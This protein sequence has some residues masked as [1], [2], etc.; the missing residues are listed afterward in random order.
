MAVPD[1]AWPEMQPAGS[2]AVGYVFA[3]AAEFAAVAEFVRASGSAAATFSG[4]EF[5]ADES[6]GRAAAFAANLRR[7]HHP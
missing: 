2:A 7:E 4:L 6:F 3:A 5:V 1:A